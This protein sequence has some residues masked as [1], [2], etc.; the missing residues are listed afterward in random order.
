MNVEW[1][2]HIANCTGVYIDSK[3]P[4]I[5]ALSTRALAKRVCFLQS[6]G[7]VSLRAR[8]TAIYMK[9]TW[10]S[11][12]VAT[13][14]LKMRCTIVKRPLGSCGSAGQI[15]S[16]KERPYRQPLLHAGI[17]QAFAM[18][19]SYFDEEITLTLSDY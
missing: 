6:K 9:R 12:A 17:K 16:D 10:S 8:S 1:E 5:A 14:Q 18:N 13:V 11:E 4:T 2:R 3:E 15:S 19:H 7:A